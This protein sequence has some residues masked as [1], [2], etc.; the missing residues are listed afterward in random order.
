MR[1]TGRC[2]RSTGRFSTIS[3]RCWWDGD[4]PETGIS[5][6][7]WRPVCLRTPTT[8]ED[9]AKDGFLVPPKA[10]SVPLMFQR[11]GIKHDELSEEEKGEWDALEWEEDGGVP[12]QVEAQAVNKWL[13]N[14][15][16]VDKVLENLMTSGQMVEC[17]DKLG[18]T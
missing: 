16:T 14:E 7:N 15:D 10:V 13:F 2:I 1:R 11:Q 3:I 9:A 17:G 18:K 6:F 5:G 4:S 8:F 12:T